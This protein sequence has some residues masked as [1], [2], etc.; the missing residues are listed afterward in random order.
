MHGGCGMLSP[1]T[2]LKVEKEIIKSLGEKQNPPT[3]TFFSVMGLSL[4]EAS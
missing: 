1:L 2:V 4:T 3:F